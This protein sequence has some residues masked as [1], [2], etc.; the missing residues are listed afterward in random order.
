M[1]I[2]VVGASS[3]IGWRVFQY[4]HM[5]TKYDITGTYYKN[6]KSDNL[7]YLDI[8]NKVQIEQILNQFYPDVILWI[9]GSKNLKECERS[10][11]FAK[12]INTYPIQ[13]CI[14]VMIKNQFDTHFAFFSTDYIFDGI[15]GNFT[16]TDTPNPQTNYGISNNEA[17]KIILSSSVKYSIIRT[18]AVMG[19]NGTFFDWLLKSLSEEKKIELF[20]DIYFTPTPIQ[21]LNENILNVI[22]HNIIGKIHICGN[23]KLSRFEFA[24]MI[25]KIYLQS[26]TILLPQHGEG[27]TQLFQSNLTLEPSLICIQKK[28]LE[29]YLN[30]E[31]NHD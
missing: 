26:S 25:K 7:V 3:F 19:K 30:E 8:T 2:L 20:D 11:D 18:S 9:A 21:L 14:E 22:K 6:K 27:K 5:H 15:Q 29:E 1:R 24:A 12:N 31:I 10:L 4:L 13:N 17:E 16:D 23:R 28:S